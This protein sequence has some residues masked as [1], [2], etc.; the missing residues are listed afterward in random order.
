[1][2]QTTELLSAWIDSARDYA[3][4]LV[5]PGGRV[6]SWN[7]GAERILGYSEAEALGQPIDVF[8]TPEDRERGVPDREMARARSN[9]RASDDRW[10]IRKDGSRFWCSGVLMRVGDD[11]GA[12]DGFVKVM[13][14]LTE[15]KLMEERLRSR[16]E[17]LMEVDRRRNEFLA[18]LSHELR[19][20]LTP[21]LTAVYLLHDHLAREDPFAL[22][23]YE[24]IDRQSKRMKRLL[25][26]LMDAARA[27]LG[28]IELQRGPV[29]LGEVVAR[30][31]E[32]LRPILEERRQELTIATESEPILTSADRIRLE[33]IV[34]ALVSNAIR[35]TDVEGRIE[36]DVRREEGRAVV[37][38]RDTGVGMDPEMIARAFDLFVQGDQDL[39]R[40]AGG[41]GIGLAL[42]L[43]LARLHGGELTARSEG[44]GKG[45]EFILRL[46]II[47][48]E[49]ADGPPD[50]SMGT[51]P[52]SRTGALPAAGPARILLVDD[53]LDAARS[54]ELVLR[55]AG[56]EVIVAH[57]GAAAIE[58]ALRHRPDITVLD[59]G[60]PRIDGYGV[61]RELRR[62]TTIPL[63][64]LTG[65]APEKSTSL[66]FHAYLL[67]PVDPEELVRVLAAVRA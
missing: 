54:T 47:P 3:I 15:R 6:S 4:I 8:F 39:A 25:D 60:L 44:R 18:V 33:Q 19:N 50:S 16:T 21:I 57:D 55:Q 17:E 23:L 2:D 28:W 22:E 43:T 49:P 38:V 7:V 65:Y 35:F 37:R 31:V 13:R 29:D 12:P 14:D 56:H 52:G 42:A 36:I 66:L 20:P 48:P 30:A 46:P 58:L 27:T 26:S 67:K 1:M 10:H 63:V 53:N 32:P 61:A 24:M 51:D 62:R 11:P 45:S 59:V 41:L 9:G 40:S 34:E 5:D 64:A